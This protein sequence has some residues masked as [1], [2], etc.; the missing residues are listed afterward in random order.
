MD[1][2]K[3]EMLLQ[4]VSGLKSYEWHRIKQHVDAMYSSKAAKVVFDD[5][6]LELIRKNIQLD[7]K[8]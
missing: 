4:V 8:K 6:E 3:L 1:Q 5:S 7:F 2:E